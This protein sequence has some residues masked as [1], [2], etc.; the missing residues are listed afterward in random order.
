MNT[1]LPILHVED[2][3]TDVYLLRYAFKVAGIDYPI[4]NV[5]DGQQAIDYIR[6]AGKFK[7]RKQYPLPC[8]VLLDLKLPYVM[9]L[10][11]LQ[12]I[13]QES[14]FKSLIVIVLSSSF[15]EKDVERAY[16]LGANAFLIKP[17]DVNSF[18]D[19]CK[20]ISHFWLTYNQPPLISHASMRIL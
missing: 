11:V 2:S 16:S 19:M 3:D 18:A 13:R 1:R 15:Y 4:Q 10:D 20:A 5:G 12:W 14:R 17:G 8:A 6:G 7:D 9:G